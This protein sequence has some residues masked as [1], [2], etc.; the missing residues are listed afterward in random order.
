MQRLTTLA[1]ALLCLVLGSPEAQAYSP[2][3]KRLDDSREVFESFTFLTEQSIP[4]WL[5]ERAYG[6]VVVPRLIKGALG[7]G[8]RGGRGVMAVRN[9]DG[10]W[11]NPVFVTLAGVNIGFQIGVQSTDV[12][13]VLMSPKSVEG[14][15]GGKVTLGADA[16]VAAGPVGRSAAAATDATLKAQVLSYS[17]NEGIFAGVA[18]DGTVIS[19]DDRSNAAAYGVA[20]ILASQILGGPTSMAPPTAAAFSAALNKATTGAATPPQAT[21]PAESV[22]GPTE[23]AATEPTDGATTYPMEDPE[24][25]APPPT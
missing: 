15:A 1:I 24:P 5:L 4:G 7:I 19:V 17:R 20:G 16:S 21:K 22:P 14:I 23:P 18:L 9:P 13:L 10:S 25:G 3:D 8:G 11:S 12:V 6:V 2:T